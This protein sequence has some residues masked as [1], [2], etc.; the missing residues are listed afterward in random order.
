MNWREAGLKIPDTDTSV[1]NE[2]LWKVRSQTTDQYCNV[3]KT[4][5]LCCYDHCCNECL[6][7]ICMELCE[8]LYTYNWPGFNRICKHIHK[9]HSYISR[10]SFQQ[11]NSNNSL[12]DTISHSPET[13][14]MNNNQPQ[15]SVNSPSVFNY[16][17]KQILEF[18]KNLD[19]LKMLLQDKNA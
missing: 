13:P 15:G 9:I 10:S 1:V 14:Q 19:E 8:H 5:I 3:S 12:F 7:M 18:Y 2:N 16:H 6:T 17:N 11:Y 4:A